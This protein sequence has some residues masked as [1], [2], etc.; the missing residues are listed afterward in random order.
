LGR[1][2]SRFQPKS[3]FLI[4][5]NIIIQGLSTLSHLQKWRISSENLLYLSYML[6]NVK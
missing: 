5:Y 4:Y 2:T 3:S 6:N 1:K